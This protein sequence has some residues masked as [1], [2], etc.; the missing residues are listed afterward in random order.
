[1]SATSTIEKPESRAAVLSRRLEEL[2]AERAGLEARL[3]ALPE[4]EEAERLSSLAQAPLQ[5]SDRVGGAVQRLRK[6]R[7][8]KASSLDSLGREIVALE[9]MF[10]E[11]KRED[12]ETQLSESAKEAEAL[13]TR[14]ARSWRQAGEGLQALA[15]TYAEPRSVWESREQRR[16]DLRHGELANVINPSEDAQEAFAGVWRAPIRPLPTT[17]PAFLAFLVEG[18]LDPRSVGYRAAG[19]VHLD[20]ERRIIDL[21]PDLTGE[22]TRPVELLRTERWLSSDQPALP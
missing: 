3:A 9:R 19:G 15:E 21:I 7:R 12:L 4:L 5:R 6:E 11:A 2:Y 10:A 20:V 16:E 8:D 13:W 18:A 1:V 14:E 22:A 17:L